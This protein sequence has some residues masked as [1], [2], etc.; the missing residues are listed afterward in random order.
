MVLTTVI[1]AGRSIPSSVR[2]GF[3][4]KFKT[5][6]L[7]E[8]GRNCFARRI[9]CSMT[10][11]IDTS[12]SRRDRGCCGE[13]TKPPLGEKAENES[14]DSLESEFSLCEELFED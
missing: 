1:G 8:T 3:D 9:P 13:T 11:N 7:E 4:E 2:R 14:V 6:N 5:E 12:P 10:P